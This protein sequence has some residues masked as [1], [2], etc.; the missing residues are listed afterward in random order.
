MKNKKKNIKTAFVTF[1][2]II[3]NT[4][5]S[6][7]MINNR[8]KFWPI[9]KKIFQMSNSKINYKHITTVYIQKE[10]PINKVLK[11]PLMIYKIIS[12]LKNANKKI[13]VIEGASWIF[14][15]FVVLLSIKL[16]SPKTY[17]LYLSHNVEVEIRKNNSN[18]FI[19]ILTKFLEKIV[20]NL[21]DLSTVV[22]EKDKDK[23]KNIYNI[24]PLIYPNAL[25]FNFKV[26]EKNIKKDY[27]IY[28]G[29]YLYKPNKDA[30][31]YLNKKIMPKLL[32]KIPNL[33]L[34]L[35]G[36]GFKEKF[37][38]VINK[39]IV[40]KNDLYNLI[41][42]SKCMCV[43]LKNGS[44]TRIKILEALILGSVVISTKKGIEGIELL[45]NNP[46][47]IVNKREKVTNIL[48]KILSNKINFKSKA[49][50]DSFYYKKKYSMKFITKNF[51]KDYVFK[52][53]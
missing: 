7:S 42:H 18:K 43:P 22:S 38:W 4:N 1:F 16:L 36:G 8:F 47:F 50:K 28:T 26:K 14:F 15:S 20:F 40:S 10:K 49:K 29:S 32:K 48:F 27:I 39:N 51:L 46:P 33:K 45:N 17:T 19:Y 53:I 37:P 34:V 44:G 12:Y 21:S 13:L 2:P 31:D 52:L 11:L 9:E 25:D 30:I 6:A 35:T 24:K 5:G 41:Y 23:I 3:P